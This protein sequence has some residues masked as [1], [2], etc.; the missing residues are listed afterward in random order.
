MIVGW[1]KSSFVQMTENK[2]SPG[3]VAVQESSKSV[4]QILII[5]EIGDNIINT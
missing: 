2:K 5:S 4:Y 1:H 3:T